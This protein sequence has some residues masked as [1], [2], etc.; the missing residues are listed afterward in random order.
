M[1]KK[2][3]LLLIIYIV[4]LTGCSK[5]PQNTAINNNEVV[6]MET[7]KDIDLNI[8]TTDKLLYGMVKNIVGDRH[9]VEYMF[10]NRERELGFQ[11][12]EDS[13]N[14]IAKKDLFIYMGAG[15]EPWINDFVDKLNKNK[16]GVINVSRGVKLLSYSKVVKYKD[17]VLKDNPYYLSNLDNY[18]IALMNIK[19]SIQDKDPKNRDIYEKNFSV[20]LKNLENYQKE[21]KSACDN[22]TE[23][24]FI[25]V[26]DELSYF[27][28]YNNFKILDINRDKDTVKIMPVDKTAKLDLESKLKDNKKIVILYNSDEVLKSNEDIIK[29]Y[30]IK[31][32]NM[33]TYS[34]DTSYEDVLK[35][36][37]ERLK[38]FYEKESAVK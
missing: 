8:I 2:L 32:I 13:L 5:E 11:F 27:V 23:F 26:E 10:K 30:N 22:L 4:L 16:V 29:N 31:A 24:T 33:K 20:A 35:G 34:I 1:Q 38:A 17:S 37:I 28:K 9:L 14:N 19:N 3:S 36:N 25:V 15:L 18:K 7:R 12:S 21:L 6:K